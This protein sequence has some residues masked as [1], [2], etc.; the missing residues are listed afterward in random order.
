MAAVVTG[1]GQGAAAETGVP[2]LPLYRRS[3]VDAWFL[4]QFRHVSCGALCRLLLGLSF[5]GGGRRLAWYLARNVLVAIVAVVDEAVVVA[6]KDEI[7]PQAV[8]C[9]V[10][11]W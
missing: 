3:S 8:V 10:E 4:F 2:A 6:A 11:E 1:A 5:G 9:F 7:R